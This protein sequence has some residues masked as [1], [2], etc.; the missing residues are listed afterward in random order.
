[1]FLNLVIFMLLS[2]G[3]WANDDDSNLVSKEQR[4]FVVGGHRTQRIRTTRESHKEKMTLKEY[5]RLLRTVAVLM[6][7]EQDPVRKEM[8]R[9]GIQQAVD[10]LRVRLSKSISQDKL[11]QLER[12]FYS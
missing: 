12:A 11:L 2:V 1:M 3:C 4:P 7:L 5:V 6:K 9:S 10:A 8:Y